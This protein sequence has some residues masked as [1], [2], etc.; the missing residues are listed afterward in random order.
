[1]AILAQE[2]VFAL[3][4]DQDVTHSTLDVSHKA[5]GWTQGGAKLNC[6]YA[7]FLREAETRPIVMA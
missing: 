4:F 3:E 6:P 7:D 1:M 5:F 2:G